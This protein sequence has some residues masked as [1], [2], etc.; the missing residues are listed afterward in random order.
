MNLKEM[1]K[2]ADDIVFAK[3][4][5]H[6]DDLEEAV[7]RGTLEHDTYKQIAKDFDCSVSNVRNAGSKLWKILAKELGEDVNKSNFKSAME[8]LQNANLFNFAQDVVVSG[9][10]NICGESR[11]PPDTPN[12]HQQNENISQSESIETLHNDLSEMPD[13]G[14]FYN[15]IPELSTLTNWILQQRCRLIA[16]TGISG[17]GKT[18]LTVQLVQ[19]IKDEFEYVIWCDFD[20]LPILAE[21]Q[22][23]LIRIISQSEQLDL[24]ANN[25]K[26]LPL[27]KYLQK[28]RCLVVLDN[29]QNLFSSGELAGKYKPE[30]QDYRTLF[31]QIKELSH[32]SCVVLIGWEQPRIITEVKSENSLIRTLRLTG[33]DIVAAREIFRDNGLTEIDNW[34]AIIQRYQ[35]NPFWLNSIANLMQDLGECEIKVLIN[36]TLLLPEDVKDSLQ[37]QCDRLSEIEKQV[38]S[39]L[40]KENDPV[41]LVKLLENSK[42][43]SSDLINAL[44]SLLKR[45]L[46]EQQG[47]FYTVLPLIKQYITSTN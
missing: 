38:L 6:L 31:K 22:S 24:S 7:L 39:L 16:I 32:Q 42:I 21:F 46:I 5:K 34:D 12:P 10:F 29:I 35:G 2:V 36:D 17:I 30:Y 27:I 19:Q 44:Q 25:Q 43:N 15:R 8:R 9:S 37:Q 45:C 18:A 28:Y 47:N 23:N 4:G 3:T 14:A 11:H 20:S 13:L 33:L 26:F 41:N 40:A 1:L